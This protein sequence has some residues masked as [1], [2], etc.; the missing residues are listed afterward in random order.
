MSNSFG[1]KVFHSQRD[2]CEYGSSLFFLDFFFGNNLVKQISALCILHDQVEFFGGLD[3]FIELDNK[4]MSEFFHDFKLASDSDNISV[5]KDEIL[6][7]DLD[8]DILLCKFMASEFN[9]SEIAFA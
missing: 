4:G 7:E 2:L 6:F 8:C 9:F 1:M 3:D 5:L